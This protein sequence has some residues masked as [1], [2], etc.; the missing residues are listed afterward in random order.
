MTQVRRAAGVLG[1]LLIT[2]GVLVLLFVVW[3]LWWTD[4][5]A[6]REQA[7]TVTSLE[8]QFDRSGLPDRPVVASGATGS[9]PSTSAPAPTARKDPLVTFSGVPKGKAFAIIRVP[10]YGS[11]YARPI[12]QGT[13]T[14]ILQQGVGHYVGTAMPGQVGNFAIAGHRTTYG[15]PFHDIDKLQRGDVVIIE[16]KQDYFVYR[17]RRH[18][19]VRPWQTDVIAP[20]PQHTGEQPSARWLTMTSCHP[21]YSAAYRYISFAKLAEKV[22][23]GKGLPKS[24]LEVKS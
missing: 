18:T 12:L 24:L 6:G 3:Q 21:K 13:G 9:A 10:R 1:E 7:R 16:T 15:R 22:P 20:V 14:D 5:T 8:Q 19:I 4:V 23:R 11:D 2:A 17:V